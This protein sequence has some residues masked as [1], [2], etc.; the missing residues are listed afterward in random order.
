[1]PIRITVSLPVMGKRYSVLSGSPGYRGIGCDQRQ[2]ATGHRVD[3][4]RVEFEQ[5]A[6]RLGVT[7]AAWRAGQLFD[8]HRRGV[9][10][11]VDDAADGAGDL[12]AV[13]GL[14]PGQPVV[15]PQQFGLDDVGGPLT[16]R[17]HG[18]CDLGHPLS[19]Q[20]VGHLRGD[21]RA[22]GLGVGRGGS[23]RGS[24]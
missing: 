24:R 9:Q 12:V 1:M 17:R 3:G 22:G 10:K 4:L 5:L 7:V 14:Q 20:V 21:D 11:L 2:F 15:E 23:G 18:R 13:R 8:A 19:G 6:Q 16:Q